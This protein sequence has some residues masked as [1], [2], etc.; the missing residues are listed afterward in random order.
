MT[1][2][3]HADDLAFDWLAWRNRLGWSQRQAAAALDRSHMTYCK[4]ENGSRP[5]N[6][7]ATNL[8]AN[9]VEAVSK[10]T[11]IDRALIMSI[12]PVGKRWLERLDAALDRA[13]RAGVVRK[14]GRPRKAA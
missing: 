12:I 9:S 7:F 1:G 5:R 14:R 2:N 8:F 11:E 10:M 6:A 4:I 13:R 3:L